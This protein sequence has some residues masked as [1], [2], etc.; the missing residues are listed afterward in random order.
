VTEMV[1]WP[2]V[3]PADYG[4][5]PAGPQD[6]CLYCRS[7]IGE[8]HG[9][10]CVTVT[11][12]VEMC[13]RASL[14]NGEIVTGLWQLDEPHSWDARMIEFHKNEGTWCAG[15]FLGE[16]NNGSVNWNDGAPWPLLTIAAIDDCLCGIL[17][18]EFVRVIDDTPR[19][20]GS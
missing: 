3:T 5:R 9:R 11:K 6:A 16:R 20:S 1:S 13:V 17:R 10:E 4:I 19:R 12:R 2:L 8:P 15:N 7:R 14:P 18:F